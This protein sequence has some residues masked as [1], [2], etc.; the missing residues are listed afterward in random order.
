MSPYREAAPGPTPARRSQGAW[1]LWLGVVL[2]G[3]G[4][5][6]GLIEA[7][8]LLPAVRVAVAAA[9]GVSWFLAALGC[10]V[11]RSEPAFVAPLAGMG[12][13]FS[14]AA[15]ILSDAYVL[16]TAAWSACAL[17]VVLVVVALLRRSRSRDAGDP[18]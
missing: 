7:D 1:M 9:A 15:A 11:E 17:G 4:L 12:A 3:G 6:A 18:P 10:L 5:A 8:V 14:I 16:R 2:A 13:G